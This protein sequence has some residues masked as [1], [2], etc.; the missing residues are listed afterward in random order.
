[1]PEPELKLLLSTAPDGETADR[2]AGALVE[3]GLAACVQVLPGLRSVYRWQGELERSAETLILIK[4]HRA[5]A[6]LARLAELHPYE[7]PE[8]VVIPIESGLTDYLRWARETE[9]A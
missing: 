2:I 5:E 7:V 9:D 1:V 8:G 4:S 3:E 6:C